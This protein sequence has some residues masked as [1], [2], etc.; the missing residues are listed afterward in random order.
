[1]KKPILLT[2]LLSLVLAIGLSIGAVEQ[3]TRVL[4]ESAQA[5]ILRDFTFA[6][7]IHF[8]NVA[9]L[10][11]ALLAALEI[12]P[13]EIWLRAIHV[14][15]EVLTTAHLAKTNNTNVHLCVHLR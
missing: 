4:A 6:S 10:N 5:T 7:P 11:K 13:K 14:D 2:L 15:G 3:R 12:M 9:E 1:M 8:R